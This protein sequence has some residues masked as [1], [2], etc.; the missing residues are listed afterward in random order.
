MR[1]LVA[2]VG[3][4]RVTASLAGCGGSKPSAANGD[5]KLK[6]P[7]DLVQDG[8]M[9]FGTSLTSPPQT[10][11]EGGK[12]S[13]SDIEIAQAI[14]GQMCLESQF[15]NFDFRGIRPAL[16]AKKVDA[17]V[18][19]FGITPERKPAFDFLPYFIGGQAMLTT[20]DSGLKV[21][22]IEDVC[23]H[24]F[25]V[26]SGSVELANL[27]T[28]TPDCPSDRPLKYRVYA[29]MPEIIQQLLKGTTQLAYI[30]WTAAAYAVEQMP[31]D[32]ALASDIFPG[33]GK[34]TPPNTEGIAVRKGDDAIRQAIAATLQ[35]G[36]Q[37]GTY[38]KILPKYG[39]ERGDVRKRV[40]G[41]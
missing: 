24:E 41:S 14:A 19:A 28:A 3:L 38:D 30:D 18:A 26:L 37:D 13:G 12:P 8:T 27:Q 1:M 15:T 7:S 34:D 9:T 39:L 31:Y 6:S 21:P 16:D 40:S 2:L 4:L 32:L 23:G 25:A 11:Q 22:G 33:R 5:C 17:A 20:K 29:S 10:S 35:E 36:Q